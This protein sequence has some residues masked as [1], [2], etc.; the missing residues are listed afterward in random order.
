MDIKTEIINDVPILKVVGRVVS[1]NSLE[2]IKQLKD[3]EFQNYVLSNNI[4]ICGHGPIAA[5][6]AYAKSQG[7]KQGKLLNYSNSGAASG[8]YGSVVAYASI[9]LV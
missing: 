1:S 5:A 3:A 6:I 9:A 7:A 8:D 2:F 4:S